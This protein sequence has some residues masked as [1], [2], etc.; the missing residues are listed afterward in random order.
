MVCEFNETLIISKLSLVPSTMTMV[1]AMMIIS[2][3]LVNINGSL[4]IARSER[5]YAARQK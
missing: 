1:M 3:W 2:R 4:I 5:N